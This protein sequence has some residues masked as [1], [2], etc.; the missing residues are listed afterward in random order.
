MSRYAKISV[1]TAQGWCPILESYVY[2]QKYIPPVFSCD[3]RVMV[4][5]ETDLK[6]AMV[7]S[8]NYQSSSDVF[9][10]VFV[11]LRTL[12]FMIHFVLKYYNHHNRSF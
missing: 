1:V 6:R 10:F 2:R 3:L 4:I 9:S 11:Q 8:S 7:L 12:K 5:A